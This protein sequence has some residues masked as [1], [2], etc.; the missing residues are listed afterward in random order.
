MRRSVWPVLAGLVLAVL[1]ASAFAKIFALPLADV[2]SSELPVWHL[3]RTAMPI[4]AFALPGAI[5][6]IL[7]GESRRVR[8]LAFWIFI[9]A[10]L[11]ALAYLTLASNGAP[12]R[13]AVHS[14]KSFMTLLGMGFFGGF[15]YW[16]VAGRHSGHLAAAIERAGF[17]GGL[18]EHGL[19]RRC[20]LCTAAALLIGLLPL[21]LLGWHMIYRP[22]PMLP[23]VISARAE[24]AAAQMLASDGLP[25]AKLTIDN[26][27][28][29]V[30][31][32]APDAAA[33]TAGFEK[34]KLILEPMVG[35]PG[36]VAY[37]QN[38]TTVAEV[39]SPTAA[40]PVAVPGLSITHISRPD[41]DTDLDVGQA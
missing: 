6:A 29:H 12:A 25:W 5:V 8:G 14:S 15:L 27:V 31:G 1:G 13:S 30:T 36:V 2:R 41:I 37:L 7:L 11:A 26:H 32:V 19:R 40:S 39:G 16:L 28:G 9:G 3:L 10:L 18:D 24:S 4:A 34:A 17:A 33:R 23:A 21:A 22:N 20:R 38:D 35:L